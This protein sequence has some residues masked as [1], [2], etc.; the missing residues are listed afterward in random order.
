MMQ[1]SNFGY[2]PSR[3]LTHIALR[4]NALKIKPDSVSSPF[5]LRRFSYTFCHFYEM[6]PLLPLCC[7][8]WNRHYSLPPLPAGLN[9]HQVWLQHFSY[10][11]LLSICSWGLT[12]SS[13]DPWRLHFL[14]KTKQKNRDESWK[15][16]DDHKRETN[17]ILH[18]E[19]KITSIQ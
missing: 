14:V 18:K 12:C 16:I 19:K 10:W 2:F 9:C 4:T 3:N 8:P 6:R 5:F 17:L 13:S 1:L 15:W 7:F 11:P